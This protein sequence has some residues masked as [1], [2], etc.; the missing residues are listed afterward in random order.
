MMKSMWPMPNAPL[1]MAAVLYPSLASW[2]EVVHQLRQR[3]LLL[4]PPRLPGD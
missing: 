3:L 2:P 1:A 4:L